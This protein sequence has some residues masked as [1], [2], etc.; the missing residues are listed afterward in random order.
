MHFSSTFK[1]LN[2]SVTMHL[3]M[4]LITMQDLL[5]K[6]YSDLEALPWYQVCR[7]HIPD[8]WHTLQI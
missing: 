2:A 7:H 3:L 8:T 5:P 4:H 1:L 6:T